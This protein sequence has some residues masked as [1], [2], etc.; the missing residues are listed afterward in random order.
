MVPHAR[1]Q[2]GFLAWLGSK[3]RN[4]HHTHDS[5]RPARRAR[6]LPTIARTDRGVELPAGLPNR[7]PCRARAISPPHFRKLPYLE[8]NV[9]AAHRIAV[10]PG[11]GIGKEVVPRRHARAR[12]GGAQVRHRLRST[13]VRLELRLL[14]EHGRMMPEDWLDQLTAYD[15]IFFGAVGWPA[16]VPDHVSLWGSLLQFRRELRPVREPAPVPA[17]AGHPVAAGRPQAG[18][19]RLLRRP[20]EHRGRV[21]VGRRHACSRAPSAR[22]CSRRRCSRATASTAILRFAFELARRRA[23]EAPDVGDQVQRHLDHDAVLGRARRR[24][25]RADIPT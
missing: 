7:A 19:H 2:F 3:Q 9:M 16:T 10:I 21:F 13:S 17:D 24:R 23:R 25:W 5:P 22:S 14:R 8:A 1:Q 11:D 20:R 18:R 15:A 6:M 12:G 4:H